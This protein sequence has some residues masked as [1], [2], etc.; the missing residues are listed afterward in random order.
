MNIQAAL[1]TLDDSH[2]PNSIRLNLLLK[3]HDLNF[4]LGLRM[5]PK[6]RR[7]MFHKL[8]QLEH[9]IHKLQIAS[10]L[11]VVGPGR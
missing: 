2:H 7:A 11:K 1:K 5:C 6:N 8:N 9:E 3:I 10:S 4:L